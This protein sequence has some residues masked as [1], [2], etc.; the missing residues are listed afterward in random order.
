MTT[1]HIRQEALL[2]GRYPIRLTLKRRGQPDLEAEANIEFALTELEQEDIRW[3]LEDYLQRADVVEAVTVKQV[4]ELMKARGEELYEKVLTANGDTQA[5]WFSIRNDLADIRVEITTGVTEAAAIPWELMRDPKMDSPICLRVNAFV[6]VES[7]PHISFVP[8]P[9]VQDDR[10]RLL[11]VV[12]RPSGGQDVELRAVA[13]RLL[14]DLGPD[15]ASFDIRALR[16]PTFERLQKELADAKVA[17]RPYH[18][19]HFD[20]HGIYDDLSRSTLADWLNTLSNVT[21]GGANTGKHG[22]LLFE[23]PGEERMRPVDGQ[24]L[25]QLLHD[26]GVPVLVLNACQSAMHEATATPT[27]GD[28]VHDEVRAIGS[29]AQAV[30]DQGIP[31][32][33]GM[34]YSVYVVTAAQY[35][36]QLYAAL[37]GGRS[38]GQAASE[39]RKHLRLNPDRWVGLQP[40]SLQDWFVPVAYEAAPIQLCSAGTTD[41]LAQRQ[42]LDPVQLNHVLL[43]YVPEEGFIGRDET[44][45]AL[46]RAFDE[47]RVVLLH[48]YAGQGKTSTA[49]EFA[50]WYALTGGL[51]TPP[52]VL[53]TSFESHTDL[54]ALLNQVGQLCSPMLAA[55]GLDWSAV[56][57]PGQR[58]QLVLQIL[59]TVP[60]LWIWDN[61]EPVA[62]FPAG[63]ASSW[64]ATEQNEL[65]DF[66]KQ[67]KLDTTSKAKILLTSRRG[68]TSWLGGIPRRIRMPRMRNADAARLALKLGEERGLG[69]SQIADWQPL[70][71]YCAGNPLTLRVLV[72]QA[73]NAGLRGQQ[74]LEQFVKAIR[75]GEQQIKD[76]DEQQG[77]DESL[78][79]SL[80]YGFRHAFT[81]DELPIIALLHLFQ[82]TVDVLA[83]YQMGEHVKH[84]LPELAGRS[85][86]QL[87]D[88]LE[89]A[90]DLGLLTHL[91]DS[92]FS[93]HPALPWFLRQLFAHHYDGRAGRSNPGVAL[94]AWVKAIAVLGNHYH[95]LFEEGHRSVIDLLE[96]E[97]ANLLHARH[98]ARG[99]KWWSQVISC[100]QGIRKLYGYQGR[101]AEWAR[102]VE[103]IR[104]DYCTDEDQPIPGREAE[105]SLVMQYR[106]ALAREHEHD[107]AKAAALQGKK[108]TE[109]NRRQ[110]AAAAVMPPSGTPLTNEQQRQLRTLG[111]SAF[112]LGQ[113]L[114][115]QDDAEC[116]QH[117][118]EAIHLLR[119]IGD[120]TNAAICEYNLGHA[121]LTI[122]AIRDLDAAETAYRRGHDLLASNDALGRSRCIKA[123]GDVHSQRLHSAGRRE[124]PVETLRHHA[125]AAQACYFDGLQLCPEDAVPDLASIHFGLGNIYADLG[126]I[127]SDIRQFD[128]AREH[129]EQ[130]AQYDEKAGNHF[131]AGQTR[132]RMARMYAR[133]AEL[134]E[135]PY[136]RRTNLHRAR[137]YAEAALRDL[138]RYQGRAAEQEEDTRRLIDIVDDAL[139]ALP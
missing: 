128:S 69:R 65:R 76:A 102:L 133:A 125:E 16:P 85:I 35:I 20:G 130:A 131:H 135:H 129:Y 120:E 21:L 81:D 113:V 28:D 99:H 105:Y 3:Y 93:I 77:R 116:V 18:I 80:D 112:Q 10:I 64:T 5:L 37:A 68:E 63:T 109:L 138:N 57:E 83:L 72:G 61:V 42:E 124:A 52:R 104:S 84:P 71:D 8:I 51:S 87:T 121:Y 123:I 53:F 90:Q 101:T 98:H 60:I 31:A 94:F 107:P 39:G 74:Q 15:R 36:G 56:N 19:V 122:P 106:F 23:H 119:R 67:I 14:Q 114:R 50:R 92:R 78:G 38:F 1:L 118:L 46:D 22:Y 86:E 40:R 47:H 95:D 48:A 33:L 12:C 17:G 54:T 45:L 41:V 4:E 73:I 24:T 97:E 26:N 44:I 13:N 103:E 29:L 62:G 127:Y 6:R 96:L 55:Q 9:P 82:G 139:T 132:Y 2:D 59:R 27:T 126:H 49:V 134:V 58:R 110:A 34:R 75:S 30:V 91:D 136:Q 32:V 111:T 137:A 117:Y 100:M 89:R 43:R 88:L 70:L 79:A 66:L 115:E 11:Y 7:R 25:G 108:D